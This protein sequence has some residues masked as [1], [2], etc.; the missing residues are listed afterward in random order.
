MLRYVFFVFGEDSLRVLR[1]ARFVARYV[2]FGFR[3]VDEI[4]ALMREMIY[5]GELEYLTFERVWKETESVFIIRN[6]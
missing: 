3:I 4:L 2:Y 1:V 6:L 5:A